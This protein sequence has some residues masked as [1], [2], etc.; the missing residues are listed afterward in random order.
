[1]AMIEV[2]QSYMWLLPPFVAGLLVVC[3]HV[4]FGQEV[5]RRGIIFIDL[6][7]A[8]VAALGV[9][10]AAILGLDAGWGASV[11]SVAAALLAAFGLAWTE[12]HFQDRQEAIIGSVYIVAASVLMLLL[13]KDPHAGEQMSQILAG[14]ILWLDWPRV[15]PVALLYSVLLAL[16]VLGGKRGF[17]VLFAL[18]VT[19]SVQL[20]GLYL[21]FASLVL[22]ALASRGIAGGWLIGIAGY[23]LG[24][25]LSVAFDLP[26]GP[27]I[28]VALAAIA[29]GYNRLWQQ[30][31]LRTQQEQG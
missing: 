28:V 24:F 26:A 13:A 23:A 31:Y 30:R 18:M 5:L 14:Q 3:S 22:P 27:A 15:W 20:V 7:I 16:W 17:Y 4:V 11:A 21:V 8:Q 2:L 19:Y 12:R 9:V 29:L 6:T 25:V 10:V 1:M